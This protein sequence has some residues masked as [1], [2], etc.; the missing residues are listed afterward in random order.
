MLEPLLWERELKVASYQE[1]VNRGGSSK[2]WGKRLRHRTRFYP[3][4]VETDGHGNVLEMPL[5]MDKPCFGRPETYVRQRIF[6][7]R[8]LVKPRP[9]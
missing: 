7:D 2:P 9:C 1:S 5:L 6:F 8:K 3:E 4:A